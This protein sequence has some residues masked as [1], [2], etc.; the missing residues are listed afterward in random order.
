LLA[1]PFN[2]IACTATT[3]AAFPHHPLINKPFDNVINDYFYFKHFNEIN[4]G[5]RKPAQEQ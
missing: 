2:E 4:Q 3:K 1:A 5:N